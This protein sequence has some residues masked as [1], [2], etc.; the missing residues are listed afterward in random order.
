M[1]SEASRMCNF[2]NV[3]LQKQRSEMNLKTEAVMRTT[4]G[5]QGCYRYFQRTPER[6]AVMASWD[7]IFLDINLNLQG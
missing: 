2:F 7:L 4:K 5:C 6:E 3:N 1:T